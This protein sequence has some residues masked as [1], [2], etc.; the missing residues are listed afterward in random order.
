MLKSRQKIKQGLMPGT[1]VDE[2]RVEFVCNKNTGKWY[3][4]NLYARGMRDAIPDAKS[5]S[6]RKG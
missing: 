5:D 6:N 3:A 4:A 1:T 2:T